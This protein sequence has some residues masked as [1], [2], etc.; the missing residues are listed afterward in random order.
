MSNWFDYYVT[1]YFYPTDLST[2][3]QSE[4]STKIQKVESIYIPL[5]FWFNKP[6][7]NPRLSI[8]DAVLEDCLKQRYNFTLINFGELYPSNDMQ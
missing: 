3:V 4:S 1:Q 5:S 6:H 2:T 7:T 8:P